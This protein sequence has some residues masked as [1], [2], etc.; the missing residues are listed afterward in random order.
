MSS[1]TASS[2]LRFRPRVTWIIDQLYLKPIFAALLFWQ[3]VVMLG[4]VPEQTLPA[5]L[6]VAESLIQLTQ[7]GA[8]IGAAGVTIYRVIAAFFIAIV[9]GVIIGLLMSQF[10]PIGWFLD[11]IISVAFPI[12]KVTLAPVYTLWFGF[13]SLAATLLAAT[14][15]FFPIVIAT[16]RGTKSVDR[17]LIWSARSMGLSRFETTLRIILPAALPSIMN[18]I[19]ISLFLSFVVV[20]VGE[21]VIAGSG[22]GYIIVES[23][24]SFQTADAIATLVL[25]SLMGV[26]IDRLFRVVRSRLLWWSQ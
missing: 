3:L 16:Y 19:Q 17:E 20:I 13:G 8:L 15:A 26:T 4:A 22:L 5:P 10:S 7:E 6:A 11:P 23:V 24:R 1:E 12:P 18:G 21:M 14:E 2:D 25:V 9:A